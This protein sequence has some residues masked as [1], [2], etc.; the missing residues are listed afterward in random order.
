MKLV[1]LAV[2]PPAQFSHGHIEYFSFQPRQ[3]PT[4]GRIILFTGRYAYNRV[5]GIDFY[6][7]LSH[8]ALETFCVISRVINPD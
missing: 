4:I 3:G 1:I 2:S 8:N 6:N 7:Y 5:L